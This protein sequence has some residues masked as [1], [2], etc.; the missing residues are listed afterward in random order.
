MLEVAIVSASSYASVDDVHTRTDKYIMA[1]SRTCWKRGLDHR[2]H[3]SATFVLLVDDTQVTA[4]WHNS[5]SSY[6]RRANRSRS[7]KGAVTFD[8]LE[9]AQLRTGT[10]GC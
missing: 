5:D 7:V 10:S 2:F 8:G 3:V 6:G 1:K 4:G 9:Q